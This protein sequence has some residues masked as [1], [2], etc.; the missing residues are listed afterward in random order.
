MKFRRR[1]RL[2]ASQIDDQRG[3]RFP[4]GAGGLAIGG[5]GGLIGLIVVV[6]LAL[7]GGGGEGSRGGLDSLLNEQVGGTT[8]SVPSTLSEDCQTGADANE[9]EDCRIVAVVNSVQAWWDEEFARRGWEYPLARTQFFTERTTTGCGA[10]SAA[11]GPFYCPPDQMAY[12]DL[13]FFDQLGTQFGATGGPFAQAY[14][15][16]HEYG[17]HIQNLLRI[18]EATR[19]S[20]TGPDSPAV[21]SELQADCLAGVWANHAVSTGF[22]EALTSAEIADALNAAAAVGDDRIQE[23]FQGEVN[24]ESWTHGSAEQ[25]QRWFLVGYDIG[26]IEA[27]DTFS[28]DV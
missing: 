3:R 14:I 27:C 15:I 13:G 7:S 26:T 16:A 2:D 1:A 17:H 12:I 24:P 6:V 20:D 21:R 19:S 9:R 10:A 28:G 25:R 5:G 11:V 8:A 22:I 23:R 18:L 4:G